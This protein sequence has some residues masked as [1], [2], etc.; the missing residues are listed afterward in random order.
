MLA[1][2]E[3]PVGKDVRNRVAHKPDSPNFFRRLST[4]GTINSPGQ[5]VAPAG[6]S[7]RSSATGDAAELLSIQV[8]S[9]QQQEF[10]D[11]NRT[12]PQ[13]LA[14]G[15]AWPS[16]P[17]S[18][19]HRFARWS[20]ERLGVWVVNGTGERPSRYRIVVITD[21]LPDDSV[22]GKRLDVS[23]ERGSETSWR[24]TDAKASWRCWPGRGHEVFSSQPC[25]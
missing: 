8:D 21:G 2:R 11:F 1:A 14:A 17:V 13:A 16:D 19:V 24:I 6:C 22:R 10:S 3:K 15:E 12:I 4:C 23:L 18:L 7:N 20:S 9:S 5:T 25:K